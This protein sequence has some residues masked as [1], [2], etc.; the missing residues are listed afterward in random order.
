MV[1][2]RLFDLDNK[3]VAAIRADIFLLPFLKT[4]TNAPAP[5]VRMA[6]PVWTRSTAICASV[7]LDIQTCSVRRVKKQLFS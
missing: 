6:V 7:H 2:V 3:A 1:F 5:P 4:S